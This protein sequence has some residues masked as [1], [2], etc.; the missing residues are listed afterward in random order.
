[1]NKIRCSTLAVAISL[2]FAFAALGQERGTPQTFTQRYGQQLN[3]TDDQKKQI[4]ELDAAF[5]KNNATFLESYQKTMT[6]F[7]E[8]RQAN[9]TARLDALRPKVDSLRAEMTKLRGVHEDKIAAT[10][11]DDQ[12]TKW[13]KIKEEREA[14]MKERGQR[15]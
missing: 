7:R 1:M 6:E 14:R 15:Q 4:D 3:L 11:T 2:A 9:D 12:K 13:T 5:Q 8:A 10:F